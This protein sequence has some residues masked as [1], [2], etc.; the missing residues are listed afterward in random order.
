MEGRAKESASKHESKDKKPTRYYCVSCKMYITPEAYVAEHLEHEVVDLAERCTRFLAEYQKLSRMAS[1]LSDRRQVHIKDESIEGIIHDIRAK[2][3][4][5]KSDLQN[6]INKSVD[7]TADY[8]IKS[9]LVQEFSRVKAELAGKDDDQLTKVRNDLGKLCKQLLVDISENRYEAAD[10]LIDPT[11]LKEYEE[12]LKKLTDKA[13]NDVDFIQEIRKLK[14]TKVEYSYNPLAV[15][16]MIHVD[17]QVKKP[18]RIIQF[19]REKSVLNI[20]NLDTKKV[21]S[22]KITSGFILPFRFVSIEAGNNVYLNGGDNDHQVYLKSHYLYDE[23]RGA[24]LPLADMNEARSRHALVSVEGKQLVYAI[25][26]ENQKGIL[27][28]C[29]F[30]EVAENKW[31]VGPELHE[32]RCGLSACAL[33]TTIYAVGGWDQEYLSSIERL[34]VAEPGHKW[35]TVKL[36]KKSSLKPVQIA[37]V[38]GIKEDE[39][40]IFGGYQVNETLTKDCYVLNTRTMTVTKKKDMKEPEAFIASEVKKTGDLVYAFGYEKGGVHIYDVAKDEWDFI[41]QGEVAK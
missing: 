31:T 6:D 28:H 33:G 3:L 23:L 24:L 15:L 13:A 16:G 9:P 2:I 26:G 36:A 7:E 5:A 37:G 32:T 17:A 35:E 20:Y 38:I 41:P 11:K 25:G 19:D 34:E 18:P 1:L 39:I 8:L 10:K 27:K 14:Q 4:K 21:T 30:Y 22:T 29:E 12:T 40:L